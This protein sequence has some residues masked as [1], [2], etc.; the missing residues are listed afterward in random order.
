MKAYNFSADWRHWEYSSQESQFQ[1]TY[2]LSLSSQA[3]RVISTGATI[4]YSRLEQAARTRELFTPTAYIGIRNDLFNLNL[5][6]TDTERRNSDS[7]NFSSRSWDAN[8]TTSYKETSFRF[9]YGSSTQ[10]D[11]RQ[12][13]R[14]DTTSDHWGLSAG[15]TW[16]GLDLFYDYRGSN[17]QDRV[18]DSTTTT[19]S[20]FLKGQYSGRWRKLTYNFGQQVNFSTTDWEGKISGG[21]YAELELN[22]SV[23]WEPS[24]P[25]N[26]E[27]LKKNQVIIIDLGTQ[28]V[29]SIYFYT[30]GTILESVSHNVRW[31][32]YWSSDRSNWKLIDSDVSLPYRFSSTF[33]GGRYIKLVVTEVPIPA[34][35]LNDPEVKAYKYIYTSSYTQKS[36]TYRTDASV[37]YSFNENISLSYFL[38]YDKNV[39]DPGG[40]SENTVQTLAGSWFI[41]K[42]FQTQANLSQSSNKMEGQPETKITNASL[43]IISDILDTL[44]LSTGLTHSVSQVG[45]ADQSSS[46]S[47]T[48]S[49]TARLYPDL[50]LRWDLTYTQSHSYES[51]T[52][53]T[54]LSSRI[55][56]TARIRPSLTVNTLYNY[57]QS[58]TS[59][60][61]TSEATS[62]DFSVD[63]SWRASDVVLIRV[64]EAVSWSDTEDTTYSIN[65]SFWWAI[66]PKVQFN[67]QYSGSRSG[68]TTSDQYSVFLSWSISQYLSL[69]TNYSWAKSDNQTQWTW[70]I[71]LTA[72][73]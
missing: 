57:T 7:A 50:D 5:S 69:K 35:T 34:P 33:S 44:S 2:S 47:L 45:G 26:G 24:K 48:V 29:D 56:L 71:N 36:K 58:K 59:G 38:A 11:D 14:I 27:T 17:S 30:D 72:S 46:D 39:P 10:Q 42:Y 15:R 1:Q 37:T 31:D 16:R 4:R 12:P 68:D 62:H 67:V 8:L 22:I 32:I 65:G 6:A 64:A 66:S 60:A 63:A 9:Y 49:T 13:R 40:Q 28:S 18:K 20:H 70:M 55:N 61:T 51:D 25:A 41:N 21:G 43:T 23:T 73:F 54:G 19:E 52:D 53:T 3:T